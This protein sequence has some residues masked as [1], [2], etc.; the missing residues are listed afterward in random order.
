MPQQ[1]TLGTK[2]SEEFAELVEDYCRQNQTTASSLIRALLEQEISK[3]QSITSIYAD[4]S[5]RFDNLVQLN[6][7]SLETSL[8]GNYIATTMLKSWMLV[9][10]GGR[11]PPE[12]A[13]DLVVIDSM[14]ERMK[15]DIAAVREAQK[16]L[17][18]P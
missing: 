16:T 2:V 1:T 8:E 5:T 17:K 14:L 4:L 15:G 3:K 18:P 13:K 6:L 11:V 9:Q 10:F 12:S 7:V